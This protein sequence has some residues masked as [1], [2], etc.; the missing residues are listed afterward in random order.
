MTFATRLTNW[1]GVE[2][3]MVKIEASPNLRWTYAFQIS[4]VIV[5]S[6]AET[7]C[8]NAGDAIT[9]AGREELNVSTDLARAI[10]EFT[11]YPAYRARPLVPITYIEG[12]TGRARHVRVY[13]P[14][15]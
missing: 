2:G 10:L 12:K 14:V 4:K 3:G 5:G 8:L 13:F 15:W 1:F 7:A 11:S 9:I 6:A